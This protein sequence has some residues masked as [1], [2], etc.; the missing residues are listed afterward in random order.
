MFNKERTAATYA[1]IILRSYSGNE[2]AENSVVDGRFVPLNGDGRRILE[3]GTI[4]M[5]MGAPY[6]SKVRPVPSAG[7]AAGTDEVQTVVRS[8]TP[9]AGGYSIEVPGYGTTGN[10]TAYDAATLQAAIRALHAD[11]AAMTVALNTQTYTL[12]FIDQDIAPVVV[13]GNTLTASAVPV[14]LTVGQTTQGELA[15]SDISGIVMHTVELWPDATEVYKDDEP[16]A[17][18]TKNCAFETSQLIGYSGNATIVKAAMSGAGNQR[19][20]NNTF[21]P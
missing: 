10:L 13:A 21:E 7:G 2:L 5:W 9:D 20:A 3:A 6:A 11:L 19:C 14:T 18:Y 1:K 12:T 4:M 16:A 17:L 8:A 15:A